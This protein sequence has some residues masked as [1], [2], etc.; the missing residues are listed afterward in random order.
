MDQVA[1]VVKLQP[2]GHILHWSHP[3]FNFKICMF[4]VHKNLFIII[5]KTIV[6][7]SNCLRDSELAPCKRLEDLPARLAQLVE[8]ET[9]KRL[10]DLC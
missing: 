9:L 1:G 4:S 3:P 5:F 8:H 10:E 2:I 6:W 7:S